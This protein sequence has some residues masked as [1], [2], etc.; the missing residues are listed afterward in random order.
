MTNVL[1][2]YHLGMTIY[3]EN[4][5]QESD[6]ITEQQQQKQSRPSEK[7][8]EDTG[9]GLQIGWEMALL[10]VEPTTVQNR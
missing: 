8:N 9:N 10:S 5:Q 2:P 4:D 3:E 6:Q 7:L 1:L